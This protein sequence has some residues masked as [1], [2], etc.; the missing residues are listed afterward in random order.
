M[1]IGQQFAAI[2]ETMSTGPVPAEIPQWFAVQTRGRHEKKVA[3][4]LIDKGVETFLPTVKEVHR[5]SDRKKVVEIPLFPSYGFVRIS[6]RSQERLA[7]LQTEGVV[8]LVSTG[9]DLAPV[10]PK[11]IE[12]IRVLISSGIQMMMYPF[13]KVGQR[14]RVRGGAL[15]GMEGI[16][17]ARPREYTLVLSVDAIQRSIAVN[18]DSYQIEPI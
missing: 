3:S 9:T 6:P 5:W 14:I 15:H 18:I 16:L 13:L 8:K 10:D 2:S 12:D 4:Q 17:V 7:V 1:S 11:Q